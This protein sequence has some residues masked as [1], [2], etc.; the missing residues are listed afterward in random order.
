MWRRVECGEG[1][2]CVWMGT[3]H[4]LAEDICFRGG[5]SS[6]SLDSRSD[7][8]LTFVC[9]ALSNSSQFNVDLATWG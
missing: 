6:L 2:R 4:S 1:V 8:L 5:K 7:E 9:G 3:N